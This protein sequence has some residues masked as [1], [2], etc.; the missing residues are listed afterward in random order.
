M[1]RIHY[2]RWLS[3]WL[4]CSLLL[5]AGCTS[6]VADAP[7][8]SESADAASTTEATAAVAPRVVPPEL[9]SSDQTF[10]DVGE[11]EIP[12]LVTLDTDGNSTETYRIVWNVGA[13]T[14]SE[15]EFFFR[16]KDERG[17]LDIC[18][19]W[20]GDTTLIGSVDAANLECANGINYQ[21]QNRKNFLNYGKSYYTAGQYLCETEDGETVEIPLPTQIPADVYDSTLLE[22]KPHYVTLDGDTAI[23]VYCD[24]H[25]S[26]ETSDSCDLV[27]CT[28]PVEDP[29]QAQWQVTHLSTE[30]DPSS[31]YINWEAIYADGYLYFAAIDGILS[32]CVQTGEVSWVEGIHDVLLLY[33]DTE[34]RYDNGFSGDALSGSHKDIALFR[35]TLYDADNSY[36][37][38]FIALSHNQIIGVME[39]ASDYTLTFYDAELN[40]LG[41]DTTYTGLPQFRLK[42]AKDD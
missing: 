33:P 21:P 10:S 27:Y 24:Y 1:K 37:Y 38:F 13:G 6:A 11:G 19:H 17:I 15:K 3:I 8:A 28:Y 16:I 25:S 12:F 35:T 7:D 14:L 22:T 42:W 18:D 30:Y 36:R 20:T 41:T 40:V 5:M 4:A 32:V 31:V 2:K 34:R 39:M 26:L 23:V 29:E 9:P